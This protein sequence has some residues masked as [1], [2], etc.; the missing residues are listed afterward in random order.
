MNDSSAAAPTDTPKAPAEVRV[1]VEDPSPWFIAAD[2]CAA[3]GM[4]AT[5]VTSAPKHTRKKAATE[6][7]KVVHL[8]NSEGL[9]YLLA[10]ARNNASS[11]PQLS[12]YTIRVYDDRSETAPDPSIGRHVEMGAAIAIEGTLRLY[13]QSSVDRA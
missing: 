2:V 1:L 3:I 12:V 13:P 5:N 4:P 11:R 10:W 6:D 9:L 7:G 8:V